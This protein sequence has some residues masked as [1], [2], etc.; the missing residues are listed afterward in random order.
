MS[1]VHIL[2]LLRATKG[3]CAYVNMPDG[4]GLAPTEEES[5][6]RAPRQSPSRS[7]TFDY[8]SHHFLRLLPL[9]PPSLSVCLLELQKHTD[10]RQSQTDI[11]SSSSSPHPLLLLLLLLSEQQHYR[12]GAMCGRSEAQVEKVKIEFRLVIR[13]ITSRG[14]M[15]I[16]YTS[17][18]ED[19]DD[20]D[21]QFSL[22]LLLR[23]L[24]KVLNKKPIPH[25]STPT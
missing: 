13:S 18:L 22:L 20:D 3:L 7:H 23:F 1:P 12:C 15:K 16:F 9:F 25:F 24:L 14:S 19:D 4:D 21:D 17:R 2:L 6:R 10:R 5:A 11:G 8:V